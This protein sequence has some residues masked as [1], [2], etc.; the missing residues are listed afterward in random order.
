M[1]HGTIFFRLA[2]HHCIC[3]LHP[4]LATKRKKGCCAGALHIWKQY[5]LLPGLRQ[6]KVTRILT[7]CV[8]GTMAFCRKYTD[9]NVTQMAFTVSNLLLYVN[10]N[11]EITTSGRNGGIRGPKSSLGIVNNHLS[12]KGESK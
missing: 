11:L 9:K 3:A 8:V 5:T 2:R 12:C 6:Y 4:D 7:Q 10:C 1:T